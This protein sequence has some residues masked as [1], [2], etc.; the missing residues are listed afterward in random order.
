MKSK[1]TILI[2]EDE[3]AISN[4]ISIVLTSNAYDV[5]KST[6]GKE[7]ISMAASYMPDLIL[8]DLGL[9][10]M[11]GLDVLRSIRQWSAVPIVVVSARVFEK[12]KVEALD[13]GA[14]DYV[15]KPFGTSELLARVR[16]ALRHK[17]SQG[18]FVFE[19]SIIEIGDLKIDLDKHLVF[20]ENKEIHL[21]P[22]EYKI[23]ILL[24]LNRGK[25]LTLDYLSKEIWGPYTL[26]NNALRVNMANIR[27]KI[28]KNP[29]EPRYILTEVGV[30][31]RMKEEA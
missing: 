12:E 5:L 25:V 18:K 8:L 10:D 2:I 4:F 7:A 31:Y 13:A 23:V 9:P 26:E 1:T 15:T 21:T 11:D 29:A 30:G 27:R 3:N 6:T 28:E 20:L 14:D 17:Q 19:Q 24:A 22:I 16:T